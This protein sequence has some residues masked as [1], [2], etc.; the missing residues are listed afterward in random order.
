MAELVQG[1]KVAEQYSEKGKLEV[2]QVLPL[3]HAIL[4]MF[5]SIHKL[6]SSLKMA[7]EHRTNTFPLFN[8]SRRNTCRVDN[9]SQTNEVKLTPIKGFF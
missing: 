1:S 7:N 6:K 8:F 4:F 5:S 3:A 2:P 9:S